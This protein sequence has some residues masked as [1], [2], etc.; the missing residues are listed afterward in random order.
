MKDGHY[1]SRKLSG[2]NATKDNPYLPYKTIVSL[3]CFLLLIIAIYSAYAVTVD[4]ILATVC[5][6]IITYAE[7]RKFVRG[8]EDIENKE[9]V[10]EKILKSLIDEKI[11]LCEAKKTGIEADDKEIEHAV[12]EFKQRH[13]LSPEEFNG[14]LSAE[15]LKEDG[16]R[17]AMKEKIMIS[18]LIGMEVESKI[19]VT[20]EEK[21]DYYNLKRRDYINIPD[22][23]EIKA[24]F[25]RLKEG[26]SI[27][28]I[29]DLKRKTLKIVSLLRRGEDFDQIVD[30]Y[31]DEPL[32]GQG[33]VLG[34]FFR[35]ILIPQL[36]NKA[37]SMKEG[38]ISDPV[39]VNEGAYILKIIKRNYESF[40]PY[41]AAKEDI[42]KRIFGQKRENLMN[43]W[44]KKLWEKYSVKVN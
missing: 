40:Q 26:A 21:N 18:K 16:F 9:A 23:I 43:E 19:I 37:F 7:Y 10:D 22:K 12:A 33:G 25:V 20:E 28:E 31:S 6:E 34:T 39:W 1:K 44:I 11:I 3:A 14:M 35:G 36:D 4:R 13:N 2:L 27:T 17:K 42:A 5:D 32:K 38:E 8:M 29:T 30:E 15:G 41:E 24:V